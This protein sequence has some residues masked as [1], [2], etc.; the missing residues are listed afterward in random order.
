M[1]NRDKDEPMRRR[2]VGLALVVCGM[3]CGCV[4]PEPATTGGQAPGTAPVSYTC[5]MCAGDFKA[6]GAC[7]KCGMAL[8]RA[9]KKK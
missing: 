3:L 7:P 6:M 2:T 1:T 5:P 8:T 4:G 9:E